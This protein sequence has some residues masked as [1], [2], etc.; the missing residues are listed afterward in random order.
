MSGQTHRPGTTRSEAGADMAEDWWI[1]RGTGVP[2]DAITR[3][4][5]APDW[6]AF[7]HPGGP[8]LELPPATTVTARRLGRTRQAAAYRADERE[9]QLVNLAL[10]LRRPLLITGKPGV[11][12]STLAYAVARELGLG[13]VLRW[14]ITSRSTLRDGLYSYDAI[15]RLHE[16][17]LYREARLQ[18]ETGPVNPPATPPGEPTGPARPGGRRAVTSVELTIRSTKGEPDP[19]PVES[20][21]AGPDGATAAP[22]PQGEETGAAERPPGIGSF[23]RL[24]PLGTALL[25]W[26]TPRVLLIDEMDKSD[27]D[28][29]NDLLNVFEEGEFEIPELVRLGSGVRRIGTADHGGTAEVQG[30]VVRCSQ[31]PLVMLTSN[32]EREFPAALLRRCVRLEIPP[33][34]A[35]RLTAMVA[36]HL[37]KKAAAHPATAA[38]ITEFL[39]RQQDEGAQLANDQLLNALLMLR[40][41][42]PDG[43]PGHAI[44]HD[45]LLRPLNES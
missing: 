19:A 37:G 18:W 1:Y 27:I 31:F 29:P 3:L 14:P 21:P 30:G 34:N 42:V 13:P 28:L 39:R 32:G 11:G 4:P 16:A 17:G 33:P 5:A 15:G 12:K 35:E 7:D 8:D 22:D 41:G 25:P 9:V 45:V 6:R 36:A 10:H 20:G 44:L 40:R 2:H 23:L 26:R 24:G 38:L 43:E